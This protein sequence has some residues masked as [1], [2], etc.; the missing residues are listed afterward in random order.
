MDRIHTIRCQRS[1]RPAANQHGPSA[2]DRQPAKRSICSLQLDR[3]RSIGSSLR[4]GQPAAIGMD[5]ELRLPLGQHHSHGATVSLQVSLGSSNCQGPARV[6]WPHTPSRLRTPSPSQFSGRH[7]QPSQFL[8]SQMFIQIQTGTA[9][10]ID[11]NLRRR[12]FQPETGIAVSQFHCQTGIAALSVPEFHTGIRADRAISVL[13]PDREPLQSCK[14]GRL[15][16]QR[17]LH[18]LQRYFC[19]PCTQIPLPP[20]SLHLYFRLP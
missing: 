8:N 6:H 3:A 5:S 7:R 4:S 10:I 14:P 17:G 19:L 18:S 12:Q 1:R 16:F 11:L 20:Q 2:L 9:A 13:R 15:R